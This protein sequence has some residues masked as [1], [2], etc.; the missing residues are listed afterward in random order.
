MSEI[1]GRGYTVIFCFSTNMVETEYFFMYAY[2]YMYMCFT[3]TSSIFFSRFPHICTRI[4][5]MEA[6]EMERRAVLQMFGK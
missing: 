1:R 3:N 2:I 4:S 5:R 6:R